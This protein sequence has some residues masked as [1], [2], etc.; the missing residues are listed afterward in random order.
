MR[1]KNTADAL[2]ELIDGNQRYIAGKLNHPRQTPQYRRE[3]LA[4]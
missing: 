3:L 2:Q 4:R 1:V